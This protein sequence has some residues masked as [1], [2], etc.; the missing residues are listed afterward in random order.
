MLLGRIGR[1]EQALAIY[2]H[3]LHDTQ[4]ALAYCDQLLAQSAGRSQQLLA[5][6][7][8]PDQMSQS[9]A[10]PDQQHASQISEVFLTLLKLLLHPPDPVILGV[11][12]MYAVVDRSAPPQL[13]VAISILTKYAHHMDIVKV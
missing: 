3:V 4:H 9:A 2:I 8:S 13:D 10:G 6:S 7:L 5:Q 12:S 1:H 11:I